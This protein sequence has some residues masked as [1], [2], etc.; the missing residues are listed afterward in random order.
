MTFFVLC[1][2]FRNFSFGE[3]RLHLRKTQI[4][5]VFHSIY[6]IFAGRMK[7]IAL[8][9]VLLVLILTSCSETKYVAEGDYLLDKVQVKTDQPVRG[10]STTPDGF[11]LSRYLF[12][13]ILSPDATRRGGSIA[14]C[15]PSARP[16]CSTIL[17]RLGSRSTVCRCRF[18]IW[19][20]CGPAS[21]RRIPSRVAN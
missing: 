2:T 6:T 19:V 3:D 20:T 17:C 4:N 16:P 21:T 7:K 9:A 10:L 5:L 15:A 11:R 14:C 12:I 1:S 8:F 18:R 13:P